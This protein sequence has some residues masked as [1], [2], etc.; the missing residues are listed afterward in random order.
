MC[1]QCRNAKKY[2]KENGRK[3][4]L[5]T[6]MLM[7]KELPLYF[8]NCI[9]P[10]NNETK[11]YS[12]RVSSDLAACPTAGVVMTSASSQFR[13]STP[14]GFTWFTLNTSSGPLVS[15]D[16]M[17]KPQLQHPGKKDVHNVLCQVSI[18]FE[19][20]GS[21]RNYLRSLTDVL[22]LGLLKE[23]YKTAG[24]MD[25]LPLLDQASTEIKPENRIPASIWAKS[26]G[27]VQEKQPLTTGISLVIFLLSVTP[28]QCSWI[29]FF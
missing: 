15:S 24:I 16:S 18:L 13:K 27:K 4:C 20:I 8:V 14:V 9:P 21:W 6:D 11:S 5:L 2:W 22:P 19:T 25:K 26:N 7:L 28:L 10:V 1:R 17:N 12:D 29:F 23:D 3:Q